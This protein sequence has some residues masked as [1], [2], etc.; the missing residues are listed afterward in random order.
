VLDIDSQR[1]RGVP[2]DKELGKQYGLEW[3]ERFHY[4]GT[5][6]SRLDEYIKSNA[7]KK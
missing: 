6:E 7:V 3:A 1:L 2:S 4:I 5:Q